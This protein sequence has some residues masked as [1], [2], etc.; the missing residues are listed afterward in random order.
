[1]GQEIVDII[2]EKNEII[3]SCGREE[4]YIKRLLHRIVHVL[5]FNNG[6]QILLQQR[7]KN[8]EYLPGYW[9]TS[10]GGHVLNGEAVERAAIR[11]MN[12]ELGIKA[13]LEPFAESWFDSADQVGLRKFLTV[14]KAMHNGPFDFADGEVEMADF[15]S[16]EQI[17][18]MI[19]SGDKIHPELKFIINEFL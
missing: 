17:K 7:S 13:S 16:P 14:F 12:E 9:S 18:A 4:I 5:V 3:G 8:R 2:N 10:A 15:Y 6:G 19:R 11:E 1:M